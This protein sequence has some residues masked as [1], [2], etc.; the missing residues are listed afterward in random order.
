MVI[1]QNFI[2]EF[3]SHKPLILKINVLWG[4]CN[5][6]H[7]SF[8]ALSFT[9]ACPCCLALIASPR[10]CLVPKSMQDKWACFVSQ[11]RWKENFLFSP[12]GPNEWCNVLLQTNKLKSFKT[13]RLLFKWKEKNIY[14]FKIFTWLLSF[15]FGLLQWEEI[16]SNHLLWS[17]FQSVL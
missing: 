11:V 6:T 8:C 12:K 16:F 3:S 7:P 1:P 14:T 13:S 17:I 5:I 2:R 4:N 9:V 10:L 15:F